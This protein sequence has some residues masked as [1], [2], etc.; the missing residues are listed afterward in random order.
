MPLS[1][2]N[3]GY[4]AQGGTYL[5]CGAGAYGL[6]ETG[7]ALIAGGLVYLMVVALMITGLMR[8]NR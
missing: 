1:T 7:N 8:L 3:A 2:R 4:L 5:M 6:Y